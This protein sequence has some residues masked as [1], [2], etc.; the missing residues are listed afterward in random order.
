MATNPTNSTPINITSLPKAQLAVPSDYF[1][2]QTNNGTQIIS[3]SALNVV[4]TDISGNATVVGSITGNDAQFNSTRVLS[5]SAS[6]Y[7]ASDGTP[8]ITL[9]INY[10]DSFAIKNGLITNAVLT[11]V[12]Y[13]QN[14]IYSSLF[15]QLTASSAYNATITQSQIVSLTASNQSQIS[16]LTASSQT[17]IKALTAS[18]QTQITA[19]T[20]IYATQIQQLTSTN[21]IVDYVQPVT[22]AANTSATTVTW[23]DFFRSGQPTSWVPITSIQSKPWTFTIMPNSTTQGCALS[24]VPYIVGNTIAKNGNDLTAIVSL[25]V[26]QSSSVNL[27]VRLLLTA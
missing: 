11:S 5:I 18:N 13:K 7:C 21:I 17:Q 23:A 16:S 12:D 3:F 27:Y 20:G 4:K 10:Y 14:P 1:I 19:L 9:P 15:T 24:T 26:I 6:K 25:G 2:L 22:I 8:G